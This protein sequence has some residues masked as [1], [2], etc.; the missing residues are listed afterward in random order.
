LIERELQLQQAQAA[1]TKQSQV[2]KQIRETATAHI[3]RLE[4]QLGQMRSL[5]QGGAGGR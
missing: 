2:I 5:A 3:Q 4:N 1:V